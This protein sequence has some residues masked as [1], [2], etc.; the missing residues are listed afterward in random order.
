MGRKSANRWEQGQKSDKSK[1]A[2]L[3]EEKQYIELNE[4][5]LN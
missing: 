1:L 4:K 5:S 3:K 2:G